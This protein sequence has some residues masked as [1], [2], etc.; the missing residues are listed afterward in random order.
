MEAH[1]AEERLETALK[2]V[3]ETLPHATPR[4]KALLYKRTAGRWTSC[5]SW[6]ITKKRRA[7]AA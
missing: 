5:W 4:Q 7:C 1:P 3:V 6:A 2:R